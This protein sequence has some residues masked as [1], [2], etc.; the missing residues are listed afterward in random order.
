MET[1]LQMRLQMK[2]SKKIYER[3]QSCKAADELTADQMEDGVDRA[4]GA[5]HLS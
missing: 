1:A 5:G 2:L 4:G 3:A